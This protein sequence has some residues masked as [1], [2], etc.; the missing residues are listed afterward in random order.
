M[1][2]DDFRLPKSERTA[3]RGLKQ[4][5][6]ALGFAVKKSVLLRAGI[7]S[8]VGMSDTA[9]LHALKAVPG[10]LATRRAKS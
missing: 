6:A 9:L 4:K 10:V 8:L 2:R 3:L 1:V 7:Q 5:A